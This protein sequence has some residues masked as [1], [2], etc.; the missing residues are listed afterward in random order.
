MSFPVEVVSI[1]SH[2]RKWGPHKIAV[3]FEKCK[4]TPQTRRIDIFFFFAPD[5]YNFVT[6]YV[7]ATSSH[8]SCLLLGLCRLDFS[9][10]II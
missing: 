3:T 1:C 6:S 7:S 4:I 9:A 2:Y 10:T 8:L 5:T